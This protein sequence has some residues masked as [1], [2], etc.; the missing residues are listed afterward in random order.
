MKFKRIIISIFLSLLII[1]LVSCRSEI[2]KEFENGQIKISQG[3][4]VEALKV[5]EGITNRYSSGELYIDSMFWAGNINYLYLNKHQIALESFE[6]LVVNYP[7]SK[8]AQEAR[9]KMAQIYEDIMDNPTAAISQYQE[10]IDFA[11]KSRQAA[12]SQLHIALCYDK[13]GD[14]KQAVTEANTL[15]SDY[16]DSEYI[17]DARLAIAE[18]YFTS[19]DYANTV[20]AY[21]KFIKHH[22]NSEHIIDAKFDL[23][24]SLE[25]IGK[26]DDSLQLYKEIV[27]KYPNPLLVEHR[28]KKI[29]KKIAKK[30]KKLKM[31]W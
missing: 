29:E 7:N 8:R 27:E 13:L 26:L 3:N 4:Y 12:F 31:K 6:E 25:E 16:P 19:D 2:E 18:I 14:I 5:F 23:A 30:N 17:D 24:V 1:G 28:I 15:I 11:P 22:P 10:I 21:K 9:E 20:A